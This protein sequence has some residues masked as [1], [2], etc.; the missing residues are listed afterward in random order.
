VLVGGWWLVV[1]PLAPQSGPSLTGYNLA[2]LRGL[3]SGFVVILMITSGAGRPAGAREASRA[4]AVT[5]IAGRISQPDGTP[6][7]GVRVFAAAATGNQRLRHVAETVS[8]WDGQYRLAGV[9]PGRYVIGAEGGV[10][11]SLS[12]YPS[13]AEASASHTITV[14]EG[15]PAEGIDIWLQPLPQRY[16]VSGRVYWPEGHSID[17][18]VIEYGGPSNPRKGLWYVFDPGGLFTIDGVPPGTMVM[19]ARADSDAGPLIGLASTDVSVAPVED[20]RI[21][22]DR[23]GSIAGRVRFERPLPAAV[24]VPGI[25]LVHHLL[26]VSPL[27]PVESGSIEPDG[28]FRIAGVRGVYTFAVDGLPEGWAVTR[29]RHAGRE[30]ADGISVG[31]AEAVTGVELTVGPAAR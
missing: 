2:V 21:V 30:I 5:T 31:P 20:V 18:L 23:P 10:R 12:Y 1:R 15:V 27:Y 6:A 17:N 24:Q 14:F 4:Q 22:L 29:A 11:S 26:R 7:A 9:P 16:M 13:T 19:L 8:E 3:V 28:R 25:V